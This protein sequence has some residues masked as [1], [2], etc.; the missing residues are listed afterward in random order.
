MLSSHG[1]FISYLH[2]HCQARMTMSNIR[3]M[4]RYEHH[5]EKGRVGE[6]KCCLES[7]INLS[8][9][10][11]TCS[12]C[13]LLRWMTMTLPVVH[14]PTNRSVC[15]WRV[16]CLSYPLRMNPGH[17]EHIF[18]TTRDSFVWPPRMMKVL[19]LCGYLWPYPTRQASLFILF[20][21][22]ATAQNCSSL[23]IAADFANI[24]WGCSVV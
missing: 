10:L 20:G 13:W 4:S 1:E 9:N 2:I 8:S 17:L 23:R 15:P 19:P 7:L 18:S 22:S 5:H 21:W 16:I 11:S 14:L 6:K 12:G 3:W 24:S